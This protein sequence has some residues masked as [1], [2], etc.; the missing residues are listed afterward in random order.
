M[1]DLLDSDLPELFEKAANYLKTIV[2]N[3]DTDKLLYFYA[4]FKQV[5]LSKS[6][7]SKLKYIYLVSDN[8][9]M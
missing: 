5:A 2:G 4:R 6:H 7:L 3:L 1:A 9:E 8:K